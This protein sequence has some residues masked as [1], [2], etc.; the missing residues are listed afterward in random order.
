MESYVTIKKNI[1]DLY[2]LNTKLSMIVFK[3]KIFIED[4][5]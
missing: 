1:L 2:A 5:V 4:Y 3:H